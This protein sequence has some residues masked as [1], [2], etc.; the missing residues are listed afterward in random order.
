MENFSA[1]PIAITAA[2]AYLVYAAFRGTFGGRGKVSQAGKY[3]CAACGSRGEPKRMTRGSTLI[4]LVLWLCFIIPGVIYSIW[5]L[6]ADVIQFHCPA[7][8][9]AGMIPVNTP[10]GRQ[11]TQ[12]APPA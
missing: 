4:E 9:T 10:R 3:V 7:C 8:G 1:L 5:R 11:L 12:G 2:I 6:M